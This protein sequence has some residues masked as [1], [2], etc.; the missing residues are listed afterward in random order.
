MNKELESLLEKYKDG[1][2]S[3]NERRRLAELVVTEEGRRQALASETPE[4][5]FLARDARTPEW[6]DGFWERLKAR[7]GLYEQ[8]AP[9]K[10]P[11]LRLAAAAAVIVVAVLVFQYDTGLFRQTESAPPEIAAGVEQ[12]TEV[13]S[14]LVQRSF[15]LRFRVPAEVL[16]VLRPLMSDDAVINIPEG[17]RELVISDHP[18]NLDSIARAL[19]Q[20]DQPPGT[21]NMR[22]EL[23]FARGSEIDDAF[24]QVGGVAAGEIDTSEFRKETEIVIT[25]I[26]GRRYRELLDGRYLV[27]CYATLSQDGTAIEL[28]DFS[29]YDQETGE[30]VRRS[31]LRVLADSGLALRTEQQNDSGETLVILLHP[32]EGGR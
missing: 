10:T 8:R 32:D 9:A 13:D 27:Q 1:S 17:R 25:P 11:W 31:G 26:D 22:L 15:A 28:R 23:L 5:V 14:G 4:A 30:I 21:L 29:I 18:A 12:G 24:R 6:D 19:A 7:I 20:L 16:A 3:A 2:L